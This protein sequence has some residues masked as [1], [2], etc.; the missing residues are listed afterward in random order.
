MAVVSF[1]IIHRRDVA[2]AAASAAR[3]G[4]QEGI[5]TETPMTDVG[6]RLRSSHLREE[7]LELGGRLNSADDNLRDSG[8]V[9]S[10]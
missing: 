1:L 2:S 8:R 9:R 6:G 4:E 5:T 10:D 3:G 7:N